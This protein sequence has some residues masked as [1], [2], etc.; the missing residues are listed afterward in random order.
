MLDFQTIFA[1]ILTF[2]LAYFGLGRDL[3]FD[4]VGIVPL[5]SSLILFIGYLYLTRSLV[6]LPFAVV[7]TIR[8]T[9][10][11]MQQYG[12]NR[13]ESL[14]DGFVRGFLDTRRWTVAPLNLVDRLTVVGFTLLATI[15]YLGVFV[16]RFG[17]LVGIAVMLMLYLFR[18]SFSFLLDDSL[19]RDSRWT[20]SLPFLKTRD[21]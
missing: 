5:L 16:V 1:T 20:N 21:D 9:R 18:G 19:Q 12:L 13:R 3:P 4:T 11:A 6:R 14:R 10:R 8:R 15:P 2:T 17:G 7:I